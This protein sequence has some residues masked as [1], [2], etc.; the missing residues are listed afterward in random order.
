MHCQPLRMFYVLHS[1]TIYLSHCVCF[2]RLTR[3]QST[4][5]R[6]VHVSDTQ[7]LVP[8]SRQ[9]NMRSTLPSA[10]LRPAHH[11]EG[12]SRAYSWTFRV[13]PPALSGTNKCFRSISKH[14]DLNS[15]PS[16]RDAARNC[17]C[18]RRSIKRQYPVK[19][20]VVAPYSVI[21]GV[22]SMYAILHMKPSVS[23]HTPMFRTDHYS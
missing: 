1:Q 21:I 6:E 3:R 2:T 8:S 11:I 10:H 23:K 14:I 17:I 20:C 5:P 12:P 22:L 18:S 7:C 19:Y 9:H 15:S 4:Y 16:T 13:D